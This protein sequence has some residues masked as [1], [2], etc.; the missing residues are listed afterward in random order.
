MHASRILHIQWVTE[1]TIIQ[2]VMGGT[3]GYCYESYPLLLI[4]LAPSISLLALLNILPKISSAVA[5]SVSFTLL[6]RILDPL[7]DG[8]SLDMHG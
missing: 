5:P 4:I 3:I 7:T 1:A 2:K 6:S 8:T